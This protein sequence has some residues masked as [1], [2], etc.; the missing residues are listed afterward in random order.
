MTLMRDAK[1]R[2]TE[3]KKGSL[4][5]FY[6]VELWCFACIVN[7]GTRKCLDIQLLVEPE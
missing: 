7:L 6:E 5:F 4:K 2:K 1:E 3:R